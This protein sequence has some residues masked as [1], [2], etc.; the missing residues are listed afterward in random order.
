MKRAD[1]LKTTALG[2]LGC[3]LNPSLLRSAIPSPPAFGLL[4]PIGLQLFSIPALLGKNP[5]EALEGVAAMGYSEIELFGPYP[6]SAASNKTSWAAISA[7]IGVSGSGFFGLSQ[8]DFAEQAKS[9]G[10]RIPSLHTDLDTLQNHMPAL[11]EAARLLGAAYVTLPSIPEELRRSMDDYRRM[12]DTFN[13]IGEAAIS[14]GIRFAYHNHGYGLQRTAEGVPFE[15][16]MDGTNQETVFLEMDIFWTIAGRADPVSYLRKYRG[17]YKLMHLK[18]M[19][20]KAHFSGDG[21]S[22]GQWT[23]L[24]PLMADAGSGVLDLESII[25][26]ARETA[27]EHFFV[28]QDL[29]R[30]PGVALKNSFD[31]L[32]AL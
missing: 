22:A 5:V 28:E 21:G 31:Y 9:L 29:V 19:A 23:A 20:K 2:S 6:F 13:L 17:R 26:T 8:E 4:H 10:L 7:L 1:F 25:R 16:L 24:F 14:E 32:N 15:I 27:V 18:D 11:A 12:A 30:D 3:S